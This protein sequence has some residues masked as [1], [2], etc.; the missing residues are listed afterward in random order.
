M[1]S[2]HFLAPLLVLPFLLIGCGSKSVPVDNAQTSSASISQE[3]QDVV[4]VTSPL[5][6]S[7]VT[8][9][10]TITGQARGPWYF[11]ASFPVKVLDDQGKKIGVGMAQAEGEWMTEDFVP[12]SATLNFTTTASHG[13]LVL[14]KDNPS[15]LPEN[16][17]QVVIPVQFGQ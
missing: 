8:S 9:P 3:S 7:T 10:V 5:P 16:A 6:G 2:H 15:G 4:M 14:E 1:R 13:S 17:A 12:F 11:E